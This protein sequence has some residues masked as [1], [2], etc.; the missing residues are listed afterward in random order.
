MTVRVLL[1]SPVP[2]VDPYC[3]DVVYTEQLLRHPPAGV[4]YEDYARAMRHGR[5]RELGRRG[6]VLH[7]AG[8]ARARAVLRVARERSVNALR[9]R[10]VL[11]REPF[12]HFV[13][14][15][16]AYDLVH[17][18]A[19]SA[20]FPG[21]DVP[22]VMSNAIAL[23]ELYL[24]ARRWSPGHVRFAS[25]V[26]AALA[27]AQRVQHSSHRMPDAAAVVCFS[28]ALRRELIERR[29]A[30]PDRL[31]VAPCF[32]EPG[33]HRSPS[34][35][36]RRVGFVATD[37]QAKGGRTVLAAF[38]LLREVRPDAELLVLGS[39]PRLPEAELARRGITWPGRVPRRDV[40]EVHLPA[41]DV[42]AYPTEFDGL[43]LTVL[44]AMA[45][46]TPVATSDY[47]AMPEVVGH[48]RAGTVTPAGDARALADALVHL[49][50]PEVNARARH[51]TRAW[52]DATY[53]PAVATDRLAA[54]YGAALAVRTSAG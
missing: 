42:L 10:G 11:F 1:V 45:A 54:A 25:R 38:D 28:H 9:D 43:P 13:V 21:L 53:S 37:F 19:F 15:P 20:A 3:G 8:P 27:R 24:R 2:D 47:L 30:A 18:H 7:S 52:F 50:D 36:P 22:L 32:V 46:G 34:S 6:D 39:A 35:V 23:E 14:E 5:L 51:R 31:H 12:R 49:L 26:D 44:E 33:V 4:E 40:V 48:G 16:G 17:C 29:S 41:M